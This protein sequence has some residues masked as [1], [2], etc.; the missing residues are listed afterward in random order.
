MN[1]EKMETPG[2]EFYVQPHGFHLVYIAEI[3]R[4]RKDPHQ[5]TLTDAQIVP[6]RM[7]PAHGISLAQVQNN[8]PSILSHNPAPGDE[9]VS[10]VVIRPSRYLTE[11][12]FA[13]A[14]YRIFDGL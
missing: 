11:R 3:V 10:T 2:A 6:P 9:V 7:D 12:P 14:E 1:L 4:P 13:M 8:Q 5:P